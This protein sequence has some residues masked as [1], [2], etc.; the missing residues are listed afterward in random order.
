MHLTSKSLVAL[1]RQNLRRKARFNT[2]INFVP[3]KTEFI[4]E[5][6]G[7]Y[8]RTLDSGMHLVI[9]FLDVLAYEQ[10]LK[11]QAL[12]IDHQQAITA[13]NV[14]LD[15]NG[16][17]Y[18]QVVDS[19]KCSYGVED[20]EEAITQLAQTTMRAAIG[21]M[22]LDHCFREREKLNHNIVSAINK[23]AEKWGLHVLRYEIKDIIA[24]RDIQIAME[25]QVAADRE[26]RATILESEAR[27]IAEINQA[28]GVKQATIMKAE[29]EAHAI[30]MV[31][32]AQALRLRVV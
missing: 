4:V 10:N 31:A 9:P 16:V 19:H 13:D 26:K 6:L 17:L 20:P 24:P 1:T 3:E 29:A 2:I 14:V 32:E 15:I 18:V 25:K 12:T 22:D 21:S 28:E 27:K 8:N 7:K 23:A 30:K 5:R 11:E